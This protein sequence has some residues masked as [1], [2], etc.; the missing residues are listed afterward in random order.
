MF[1]IQVKQNLIQNYIKCH[2]IF[3]FVKWH[4]SIIQIYTIQIQIV[5]SY[6]KLHRNGV[7]AHCQLWGHRGPDLG[8]FFI[9]K[10]KINSLND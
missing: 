8:K 4:L 2:I 10:N 9:F 1:N 3:S 5:L 6:Y 7:Q